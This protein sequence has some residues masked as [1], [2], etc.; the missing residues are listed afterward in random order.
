MKIEIKKDIYEEICNL[1]NKS[2]ES[3]ISS[4]NSTMTKTYY[5]I[6]RVRYTK[7]MIGSGLDYVQT[8]RLMRGVLDIPA[9]KEMIENIIA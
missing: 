5:L 1:L 8:F 7:L 9:Y 2:R 6:K 4:V 3:I